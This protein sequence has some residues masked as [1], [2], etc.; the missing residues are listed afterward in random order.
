MRGPLRAAED[1]SGQLSIRDF[2]VFS[3]QLLLFVAFEG[4]TR[5]RRLRAVTARA[6]KREDQGG[7]IYRAIGNGVF[8]F[9]GLRIPVPARSERED[10]DMWPAT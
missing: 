9:P 10:P 2:A 5:E 3:V 7:Q 1:L 4:L 6:F 8:P